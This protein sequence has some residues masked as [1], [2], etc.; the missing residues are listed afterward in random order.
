M[1]E[2]ELFLSFERHA[3]R[4]QTIVSLFRDFERV[5]PDWKKLTD[6]PGLF[7]MLDYIKVI[8]INEAD[9]GN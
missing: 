3:A 9:I 7:T 8:D 6:S 1:T 5:N 4:I 2:E